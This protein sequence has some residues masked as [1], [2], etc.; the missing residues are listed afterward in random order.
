MEEKKQGS[1]I[2]V[3]LA[4][5]GAVAVFIGAVT[6]TMF[7]LLR[8]NIRKIGAG[9]NQNNRISSYGLGKSKAMIE[10]E[11][12]NAF[13]SCVAGALTISWAEAPKKDVVL[14]L[15]GICSAITVVI[16][17]GVKVSLEMD[18]KNANENIE[19]IELPEDAPTLTITGKAVFS[20]VNFYR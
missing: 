10:P 19:E 4:A 18:V 11:V 5:V 13:Y 3:I 20:K 9:E 17:D 16:P 7:A 12:D 6:A 1:V 14:D 15:T 8:R 2:K